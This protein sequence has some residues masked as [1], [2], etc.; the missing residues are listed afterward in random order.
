MINKIAEYFAAKQEVV[1]VYLFG[2]RARGQEKKLS[3]VDLG[4]LL[5]RNVLSAQNDLRTTYLVELAR[6]LRKDLHIVIM[7]GA[8]EGI[9][10]QVFKH[11]KCIFQRDPRTLARFKTASYSMIAD[12]GYLRAMMEEAMVSRILGGAE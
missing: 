12:F 10:A 7:N 9:L 1:A 4:I 5:E 3:D 2:S 11:G 6:I 8:G